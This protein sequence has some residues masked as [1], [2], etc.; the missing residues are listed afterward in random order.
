VINGQRI[1]W[2]AFW[3]ALTGFSLL[4][5]L[6]VATWHDFPVPSMDSLEYLAYARSLHIAGVY[7]ATEAGPAADALPG[8]EP[9]YS[10]VI[11]AL[12][13]LYPTWS[14]GL[15]DC[16][17]PADAC[18][19]SLQFL[20]FANA[21]FL[22]LAA[23]I[24][25]VIAQALCGSRLAAI[26]ATSY[27]SLNFAMWRDLKYVLSDYLAVLLTAIAALCLFLALRRPS[28]LRNWI[29]LALAVALLVLTKQLFLFFAIL[30]AAGLLIYGLIQ[31]KSTW[32]R[33]LP[34][35][36][37]LVVIALLN[38]GWLWRNF[39]HFGVMN[40]GRGSIALSLREVFDHMTAAEHAAAFLCFARPPGPNLA[41]RLLPESYWH[42]FPL[43]EPEGFYLQGS[44]NHVARVE[45]LKSET[46]VS[47]AVAQNRASGVVV[48][49][50]L[51]NWVGY[52][53]S[54]PAVFYRGLWFDA[55]MPLS[56]PLFVLPF[57][58]AWRE[59]QW[60]LLITLSP[61]LW[62]LFIYPAISLNIQRYQFTAVVGL[63]VVAGLVTDRL[64]T[65][66]AIRPQ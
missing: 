44:I 30:L 64:A 50:I 2:V 31:R 39:A 62:S 23:V 42:R 6:L 26:V 53:V 16:S 59:K 22:A 47:E 35:L 1:H 49:E 7:A 57:L 29:G 65:R 28:H 18:A 25:G 41:K 45:R 40:D 46:G 13:K 19:N 43:M 3:T 52:L 21:V 20:K 56:L 54:M 51:G 61:A 9:F 15:K 38:G 33:L 55:F 32:Q 27:L 60:L 24:A 63:A 5:T 36:S 8:R 14:A 4:V 37:V 48:R 34:G 58:W 10:F 11:A 66:R 12:A 17:P